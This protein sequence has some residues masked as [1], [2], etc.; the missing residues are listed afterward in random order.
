MNVIHITNSVQS[1][2]PNATQQNWLVPTEFPCCPN[3]VH[4]NSLEYYWILLIKGEPFS[5]SRESK[6]AVV[7]A[8]Y[9]RKHN[10]I[11]VISRLTWGSGLPLSLCKIR[12]DGDYFEH[13]L[14]GRFVSLEEAS[15]AGKLPESGKM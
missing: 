9:S 14:V 4:K 7:E 10:H 5:E 6:L 13:T 8:V 2:S 12:L 11:T 15:Y 3:P 1:T